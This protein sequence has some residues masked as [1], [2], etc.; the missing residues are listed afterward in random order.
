VIF[1]HASFRVVDF[2]EFVSNT[3]YCFGSVSTQIYS[4]KKGRVMDV[5]SIDVLSVIFA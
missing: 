4:I 3:V 5:H 2:E 1:L